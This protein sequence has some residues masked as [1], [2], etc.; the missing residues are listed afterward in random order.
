[1]EG[2]VIGRTGD[3]NRETLRQPQRPSPQQEI[4]RIPVDRAGT[5]DLN[6]SVSAG[7][8]FICA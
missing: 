5:G 7:T 3:L 4:A 1:L 2:G 8:Y 6:G